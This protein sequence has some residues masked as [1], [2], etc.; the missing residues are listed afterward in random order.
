M[1]Q[2]DAREDA[3]QCDEVQVDEDPVGSYARD[4]ALPDAVGEGRGEDGEVADGGPRAEARGPD[5]PAGEL[6]RGDGEKGQAAE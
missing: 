2:D 4:P 1:E 3:R 5:V 6:R